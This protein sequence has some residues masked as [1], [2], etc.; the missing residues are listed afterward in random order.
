MNKDFIE[1]IVSEHLDDE[2]TI[3]ISE[4]LYNNL[5]ND[6]LGKHEL[7]IVYADINF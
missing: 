3:S 7:L 4:N 5:F 2:T 6:K 1:E